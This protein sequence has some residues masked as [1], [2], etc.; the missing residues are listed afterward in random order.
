MHFM[1]WIALKGVWK[2][3][4]KWCLRYIWEGGNLCC[5]GSMWGKANCTCK[6]GDCSIWL[7]EC[8]VFSFS[9]PLLMYPLK[10]SSAQQQTFTDFSVTRWWSWKLQNKLYLIYSFLV[11]NDKRALAKVTVTVVANRDLISGSMYLHWVL[12]FHR[13]PIFNIQ[14]YF[15]AKIAIF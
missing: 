13:Q 14:L 9:L 2:T 5:R 10:R 11:K 8:P 12:K 4:Q 6:L 15:Y 1:H 7:V 3:A